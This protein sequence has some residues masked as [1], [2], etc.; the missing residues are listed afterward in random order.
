MSAMG[1][2]SDDGLQTTRRSVVKGGIKIAY[3]APL[4]AATMKLDSAASLAA[5]SPGAGIRACSGVINGYSHSLD[6]NQTYEIV[7]EATGAT[8]TVQ[9]GPAGWIDLY[10]QNCNGDASQ[11]N[12]M[13]VDIGGYPEVTFFSYSLANPSGCERGEGCFIIQK[14]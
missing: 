10:V 8:T 14:L 9:S 5:V 11:T 1:V 2:K 7:H 13:V 12:Y 4:V 6:A 3:A